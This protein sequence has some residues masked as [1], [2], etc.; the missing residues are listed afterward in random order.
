[1]SQTNKNRFA[2]WPVSVWAEGLEGGGPWCPGSAHLPRVS[3]PRPE[4]WTRN[5]FSH[6]QNFPN[7]SRQASFPRCFY[8]S[9]VQR[10]P[11][12]V[13]AKK[14]NNSSKNYR[15]HVSVF[16]A[17]EFLNS[18]VMIQLI[19][20]RTWLEQE[21]GEEA[22]RGGGK[23]CTCSSQDTHRLH[24]VSENKNDCTK[25]EGI[26]SPRRLISIFMWWSSRFLRLVGAASNNL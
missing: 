3:L 13:S 2:D 12:R 8:S 5:R 18:H 16:R 4:G 9:L 22:W 17:I 25:I 26:I 6:C 24:Y 7:R 14:E 21:H 20:C 15:H 19:P 11:R 1:M 10:S 23:L